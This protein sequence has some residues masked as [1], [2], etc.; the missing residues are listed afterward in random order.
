LWQ[1]I[2]QRPQRYLVSHYHGTVRRDFPCGS[3]LSRRGKLEFKRPVYTRGTSND[4][5]YPRQIRRQFL[6]KH[7]SDLLKHL[8]D[9]KQRFGIKV[10]PHFDPPS[11]FLA[12]PDIGRAVNRAAT[13]LHERRRHL[14]VSRFIAHTGPL[15]S[16]AISAPIDLLAGFT[17]S[18]K[19]CV[20]IRAWAL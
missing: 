3:E 8:N 18:R 15:E 5:F 20:Q 1:R 12:P 2:D 19:Y 14:N 6:S 10:A 11:L 9:A 7:S 4:L 17:R 16:E 13:A